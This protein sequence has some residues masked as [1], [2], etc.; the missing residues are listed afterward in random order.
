MKRDR[1][2]I[3]F[4]GSPGTLATEPAEEHSYARDLL[5]SADVLYPRGRTPQR[6]SQ[7]STAHRR[8]ASAALGRTQRERKRKGIPLLNLLKAVETPSP[9]PDVGFDLPNEDDVDENSNSSCAEDCREVPAA[10]A[11]VCEHAENI[12]LVRSAKKPGTILSRS[13]AS[14]NNPQRPCYTQTSGELIIRDS[15]ADEDRKQTWNKIQEYRN[16]HMR[17]ENC[18]GNGNA[19]GET[20]S[21]RNFAGFA[22]HTL[23]RNSQKDPLFLTMKDSDPA[24]TGTGIKRSGQKKPRN[25]QSRAFRNSGAKRSP[26]IPAPVET[27]DLQSDSLFSSSEGKE[28]NEDSKE[29]MGELRTQRN[30]LGGLQQQQLKCAECDRRLIA[31]NLRLSESVRANAVNEKVFRKRRAV[32]EREFRAYMAEAEQMARNISGI[33]SRTV[34]CKERLASV[35][36]ANATYEKIIR[37]LLDCPATCGLVERAV[38]RAKPRGYCEKK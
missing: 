32:R 18:N 5:D 17:T 24:P 36:T 27:T 10:G 26:T 6:Q 9:G 8:G 15:S 38:V 25:L 29:Y 33:Q 34:D 3:S 16:T 11:E 37:A 2:T 31:M 28:R 20:W 4:V 19:L 22:E 12:N 35:E 14:R 1:V 21:T 13:D 30:L 23:C 7:S